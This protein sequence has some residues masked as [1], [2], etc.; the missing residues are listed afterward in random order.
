MLFLVFS[1]GVALIFGLAN[2][3]IY[4][5]LVL[6]FITLKYLR[7]LFAF[8]LFML[9][10]A[11]AFFMVFRSSEYLND[12]WYSF[13]ASL[14]APTYCFFFIT[15]ILDFLRF[16]LAMLGKTF[17]KIA[18]FVK[19]AFEIFVLALGAFLTYFSIYSA[20]K[21]PEFSEVDIIIPHLE[22]ELK[23]AMLTD[24]HLGKNLHENFLSDIIEKV[25]SKNVDMVVIVGDLV[26][27]NPNDLKPYISKLNDLKSSY[28][29][30]YALGNHEYYH[31]INEVLELL[32]TQTNMKILV[33]DAI[34]LGF[35]NIAGVGDLAGLRKGI[36]APDLARAKVDLN[37][38][39]PSILLAHQPKTA[40]LYDVSDFDLILSGHT[41]GGQVFPFAL[42]VK[43]QQGFVSGL[44][45]LSEKT[46]LF[47]SRG[48]GFWGPSLRTFSQSELVI[49][50][51]KG[52]K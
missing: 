49:L 12:V 35:A 51:L 13:F 8:V 48:A 31:G 17:M 38:S 2:I 25:N 40:L 19:V 32:K 34:D 23:I 37:L 3:Y 1:F 21:V 7:K 10:F 30:F 47:V 24:I 15:L 11:Q 5:R 44:Y 4:K 46:Q 18:S 16:V 29:T 26:D 36:L 20:I 22:K 52:R 28:G 39:K 27:T 50:N 42:L 33:N 43:L 9:F 6:K 45:V 41:H 14:Y